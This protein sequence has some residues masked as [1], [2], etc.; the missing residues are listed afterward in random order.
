MAQRYYV[1]AFGKRRKADTGAEGIG[2]LFKQFGEANDSYRETKSSLS[3]QLL[4]QAPTTNTLDPN[5]LPEK[6]KLK[7]PDGKKEVEFNRDEFVSTWDKLSESKK[8]ALFKRI[9]DDRAKGDEGAAIADKAL[10]K[11]G[12][13]KGGVSD[14]AA[15]A[16]DK[17]FGGF[18]RSAARAFD[19]VAPG[20]Q[21]AGV[22]KFL[23]DTGSTDEQGIQ[24]KGTGRLGQKVGSV[25]KGIAETVPGLA[26]SGGAS[27]IAK[28]TSFVEKLGEGGKIAQAGAKFI[29]AVAGSVAG[30]GANAAVDIGNGN[31]GQYKKNA[32]I[33]I[34]LDAAFPVLGK[35]GGGIDSQAGK[36]IAKI[37]GENGGDRIAMI[38]EKGLIG[39][40][41]RGVRNAVKQGVYNSSDLLAKT[42]VGSKIIDRKDQFMTNWVSDLHPV[43]KNIKRLDF[44]K[45]E[46]G[47]LFA[48]A[49][50]AIG[51]ARRSAGEAENFIAN[52]VNAQNLSQGLA[53]YDANAGK[54]LK[55]FDKYAK[56]RSELERVGA[57]RKEF[58]ADKIAG[59]E[60]DLSGSH[61]FSKEYDSLVG[62]YKDLND[63]KLSQGLMS[64][65]QYDDFAADPY[66]YIR[67][68][69]EVPEGSK[70]ANPP[71]V[72]DLKS[73]KL[74]KKINK[75]A[76]GEQMSPVNTA[77]DTIYTA[78]AEAATNR[79]AKELTA[80]MGPE[81]KV[82]KRTS[83][84]DVASKV[85]NSDKSVL[86]YLEDG[87]RVDV[88]VDPAISAAVTG[89]D[90]S[91]RL[92]MG[93][94]LRKVQEA[95]KLGT[96]GLNPV[97]ALTV[98]P[99][100]DVPS[101]L[102]NSR[103]PVRTAAAML[104]AIPTAMGIP[105]TKND[106]KL[107]QEY[108]KSSGKMTSFNQYA[109]P[110]DARREAIKFV[111]GKPD[112][113]ALTSKVT[114]TGEPL[115]AFLNGVDRNSKKVYTYVKNPRDGMRALYETVSA[116]GEIT[117][118]ATRY[119]L[120]KG[121]KGKALKEGFSD[122]AA[123]K[124]ASLA[125]RE[126]TTD[127]LEIGTKGRV[128]N[129]LLPY[130]NAGIQGSRALFRGA[131]E[132]PVSFAGKVT[133]LVGIP[134][135]VTTANNLSSP[136]NKAIYDTIPE[137]VKENNFVIVKPGTHWNEQEKRWEGI[138]LIPKPP[139]AG[140]LTDPIRKFMEFKADT[141]PS[142]GNSFMDFL[143]KDPQGLVGDIGQSFSPIDVSDKNK[144]LSSVTPQIAKPTVQTLLN[145][146][147][148]TGQDIVPEYIDT[149]GG[150][151]RSDSL[152]P[153]DQKRS[154]FSRTT[155][156]IGKK[157]GVSP[158][159]ID[160]WVKSTFG[161]VGMQGINAADRIQGAPDNEIGGRSIQEGIDRRF[162][163]APGGAV[164]SKLYDI[165]KQARASRERTS[166]KV[167]ELLL[168]NRPNE[169]K[170]LAEEY[171]GGL[172]DR[173]SKFFQTYGNSGDLDAETLDNINELVISTK[174]SAF[175]ARLKR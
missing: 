80:M 140:A 66:N 122:E 51:D 11:A 34:G 100:R 93:E 169:A 28:G 75:F 133:A 37:A 73:S 124:A 96:T 77:L 142:A 143:K 115:P 152:A 81:A 147:L 27:N 173:Y 45:G 86:S 107:F 114:R 129:S 167:N 171:N 21:S 90:G 112:P 95:F 19:F 149:P 18:R 102:I 64:K 153:E 12:K 97:F 116:P 25:G 172:L 29:P 38:G 26:L 9:S 87:K 106:E 92:V 148:Y 146:D 159:L 2:D 131:A 67:R 5:K 72:A 117:E 145:R 65:K 108:L 57:G 41:N 61:D 69:Q 42:K 70:F 35:L 137:Y 132:R 141:D 161:E 94:T 110:Q 50:L 22:K 101:A 138:I 128:A 170:R 7:S 58:G 144:F 74:N 17:F 98:N 32:L 168:Q 33:G 91:N 53:S 130:F 39:A 16:E 1:D 139:G 40:A 174:P 30:A 82:L 10:D 150:K 13:Y 20:D 121:T 165:N 49:R 47:A 104:N 60:K 99:V 62:L 76:D 43:W 23:E 162:V 36:A 63:Y 157:L 111:Q 160:S 136:E 175:K 123:A 54:A 151:V 103:A 89:F 113:R 164:K 134:T 127:F 85:P 24:Y 83:L 158:M 6:F 46:N 71:K 154:S 118:N 125:S 31:Q 68:Q 155:S 3:S 135:A 52:N 59:F 4:N 55:D 56:A 109:K 78:H 166:S 88:R 48:E 8:K 105:I 14:F 79:A 119:A 120:Y 15:G 44:E 156:A 84:D 126:G 163:Q